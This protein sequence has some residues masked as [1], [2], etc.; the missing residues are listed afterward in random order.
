M[1]ARFRCLAGLGL[2]AIVS[3][4]G[5]PIN[6]EKTVSMQPAQHYAP[7]LVDGP[8]RDQ[9]IT[10]EF[11][12]SD[13][14]IDVY[15]VLGKDETVILRELDKAK[16]KVDSLASKLGSKG[17]TLT[18]TIAAGKDYGVYLTNAAKKTNVTVKLKGN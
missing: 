15:I 18:A 2:L 10:V 13:V 17:D 11:T 14:P 4:C 7:I 9:K 12:S 3:G 16:P 1:R 8:K 5:Q 6:V